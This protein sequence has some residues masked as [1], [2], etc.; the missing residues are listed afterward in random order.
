MQELIE[1]LERNPWIWLVGIAGLGVWVAAITLVVRSSKFRR[2]WLWALL[3]LLSFAYGWSPQAGV[4]VS[5]GIPIGAAYI[6]WFWR[7]GRPPSPEDIKR[8]AARRSAQP[9][10]I[11]SLAKVRL[12]R[13]SYLVATAAT[14]L[15]GWL[16]V[17]GLLGDLMLG[18]MKSEAGGVPPDF[19]QFFDGIQLAQG[20]LMVALAGLFVFLSCRPYWWGKLL[21]LWATLGWGMFGLFL[22]AFGGGFKPTL[23][24]VLVAAFGMFA[25]TVVLQLVDPRF[26][27]SYLR[28]RPMKPPDGPALD[29]VP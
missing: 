8:D 7:F 25:A 24:W 26:G 23:G 2:K 19:R 16:A 14:L 17:S 29:F 4:M 18:Q 28:S 1:L 3:S 9:V 20:V 22:S 11:V 13:V 21:C 10:P 12:L 5:V 27:G 6:V 15:V